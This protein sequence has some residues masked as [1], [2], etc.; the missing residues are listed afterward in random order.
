MP[1][2]AADKSVLAEI[3]TLREALPTWIVSTGIGTR[4]VPT[5][6]LRRHEA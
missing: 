2:Y 6:T 4:F 1:D 5:G 3:A